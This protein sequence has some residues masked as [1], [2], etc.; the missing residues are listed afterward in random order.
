MESEGCTQALEEGGIEVSHLQ[1][2]KSHVHHD[3]RNIW[4]GCTLQ[5]QEPEGG[6]VPDIFLNCCRIPAVDKMR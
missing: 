4:R 2:I 3:L 1:I 6:V 5:R